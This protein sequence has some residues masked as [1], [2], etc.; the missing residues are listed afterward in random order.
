MGRG[1]VLLLEG[2]MIRTMCVFVCIT[3]STVEKG[4]VHT[5]RRSNISMCFRLEARL[6]HEKV[7]YS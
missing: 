5:L 6:H 4:S 2:P 7:V 3:L 1:W